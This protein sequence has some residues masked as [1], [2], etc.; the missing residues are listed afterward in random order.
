MLNQ[1]TC[2][3]LSE[4]RGESNSFWQEL[5]WRLHSD[6]STFTRHRIMNRN[7]IWWKGCIR[8][9]KHEETVIDK[10][11]KFKN[12]FC[13]QVLFRICKQVLNVYK[14]VS[15]VLFV[16]EMVNCQAQT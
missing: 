14:H 8:Y 4:A 12:A 3:M 15:N 6:N 5:Q 9:S 1:D 13:V 11:L 7:S 16:A 2:R 10:G